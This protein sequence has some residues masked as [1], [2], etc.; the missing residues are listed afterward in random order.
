MAK[1]MP[2]LPDKYLSSEGSSMSQWGDLDKS[3][4]EATKAL[5]QANIAY[6]VCHGALLGLVRDKA[7]IPWD[8]DIDI[9]IPPNTCSIEQIETA[10]ASADFHLVGKGVNSFHFDKTG[11]RRIDINMYVEEDRVNDNGN[12]T[13]IHS[14]RWTIEK[15]GYLVTK[16][17]SLVAGAI[18][19]AEKQTVYQD[20]FRKVIMKLLASAPQ[21]TSTLLIKIKD[22]FEGKR[23]FID[24]EYH[25]PS[26]LLEIEQVTDGHGVWNQPK[27][28]ELI[29]QC[30]YGPS[31]RTPI[32]TDN[33][34]DFTK[35]IPR[36]DC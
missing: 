23:K 18:I 28:P 7:F 16:L 17:Y 2:T 34:W 24:V 3:F 5:E 14:M 26:N 30:L 21:S 22:W 19:A 8:H 9:C 6:Y 10:L 12:T 35:P 13:S 32:Q 15:P 29:L 20:P 1:M 4:Y 25:Y 36:R 31:W 33:W 11:G 27:N